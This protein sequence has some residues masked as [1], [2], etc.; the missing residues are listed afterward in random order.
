M[1][2]TYEP[3]AIEGT[4]VLALLAATT[5]PLATTSGRL[6]EALNGL[7]TRALELAPGPLDRSQVVDVLL[8]AGNA[9]GF[10][11]VLVVGV[12]DPAQFDDPAAIDVGAALARAAAAHK[13]E[14]LTVLAELDGGPLDPAALATSLALGVSL[15]TY[16][17]D[18][19]KQRPAD[20]KSLGEVVVRSAAGTAPA[21]GEPARQAVVSGVHRCRDLV[22]RPANSLTTDAFVEATRDLRALGVEVE[23]LDRDA[24]QELGMGALLGVAQGSAMPPY[25]ALA[26]WNGAGDDRAPLALVGKG[27]V[28]DSGGLSLKPAKSM[29]SMKCDMAGAA[30]VLGTMHALA[31][32]RAQANVVGAIGLVENMPSSNA[33]RPGDIVR[34]LAGKTIEVL[35]TDAEGRLVLADVLWYVQDRFKPAAMIDFATLTGAIIVALGYEHAG[36]FANDD[37]LAQK[38]LGAG[39][40][41]GETLWRMPLGEP[42]RKQLE[43]QVADLKNIGRP[44]QAG[45]VVA[46][47]FLESFV[48]KVPWAHVDL[49]ATSYVETEHPLAG[50]GATG[51]G[52]RLVDRLVAEQFER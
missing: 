2:V 44:G 35:N 41:T 13:V 16:R 29:E 15:K 37:S 36:L 50:I 34:A 14:R 23:V 38:L 43:S 28:F 12:G 49:A 20:A 32:R 1:Q 48:D 5:A 22:N 7:V 8:L 42:Y 46:A 47:C 39:T 24:M 52:V 27:V 17:F 18:T 26:T 6:D 21:A 4:G 19:F 10:D 31:A 51:W 9:A 45:A 3:L 33:Q 30:C 11:R 40:A 25:V